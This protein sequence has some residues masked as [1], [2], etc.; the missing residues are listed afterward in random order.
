MEPINI[1]PGLR[2]KCHMMQAGRV[3][4][5]RPLFTPAERLSQTDGKSPTIFCWYVEVETTLMLSEACGA[6]VAEHNFIEGSGLRRIPNGQ[7]KMVNH[8][9][10]TAPA[11]V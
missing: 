9:A 2:I 4:I 11:T 1:R 3:T 7:V 10:H 6:H 5:M 8:A